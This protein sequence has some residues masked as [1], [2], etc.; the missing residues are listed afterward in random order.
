VVAL[1][2]LILA[3][4]Q[5][6][7]V[8]LQIPVEVTNLPTHLEMVDPRN[9][10][11]QITIRGL[12]KDASTIEKGNVVAKMDFSHAYPGKIVFPVTRN[13][14]QLPDDRLQL[15]NIEPSEVVFVFEKKPQTQTDP[16]KHGKAT[17]KSQKK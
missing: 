8:K 9:I 7:E 11:V 4:Q 6:F 15:V 3:G 1:L 14:I 13:L 12:R 16:D 2:W 5:N 17:D 10:H